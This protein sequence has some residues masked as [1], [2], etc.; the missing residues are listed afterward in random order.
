MTHTLTISGTPVPVFPGKIL[1]HWIE[2]A[3]AKGYEIVDRIIDRF[4]LALRC[5][6]CGELIQARLFTLT[7][8]QPLCA[9]CIKNG[10]ITTAQAADLTFIDQCPK[11]RH[12]AQYDAPCGHTLRRQFEL[13]KRVAAGETGIRCEICHHEA[14]QAEAVA[15]GWTLLGADPE[16]NPNYRAYKHDECGHEQR[17]ARANLQ[18]DRFSCG[19]CGELWSAAPSHLYAMSF[20]L[21]NSRQLVKLGYSNN[22]LGRLRDQLP[23]DKD[24]PCEILKTVR[25]DTGQIAIRLEKSLHA[26]LRNAYPATVVDPQIY[27]DHINVKSEIYEASL[28]DI[29]LAELDAIAAQTLSPAS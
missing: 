18:T 15:R 9:A 3:H 13:V 26:K 12:Y 1:P 28:T 20:T 19:G 23:R 7:S 14:E 5:H 29:I 4:H 22:P 6:L 16:G 24:M 21:P 11:D 27:R 8:A 25:V 10:W 17:I 2:A